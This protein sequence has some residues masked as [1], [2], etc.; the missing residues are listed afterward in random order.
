M[1]AASSAGVTRSPSSV[2]LMSWFWQNWQWRLQRVKKIV[3]EPREPR[4]TFSSPWCGP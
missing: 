1:I 4:S 3:P 2:W